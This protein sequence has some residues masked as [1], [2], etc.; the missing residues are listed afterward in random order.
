MEDI[1]G[2]EPELHLVYENGEPRSFEEANEQASWRVAMK[3]EMDT[4]KKNR[5]WEQADLPVGHQAITLKWVFKLKK[6]RQGRSTS[7]RLGS[8]RAGSCS[9]RRS[10]STTPSSVLHGLN[11]CAY[12]LCWKPRRAG[13]SIT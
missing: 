11:L 1:L 5:T 8:W 6:M 9:R 12:S 7:T 3:R 2:V 13:A 10:T 4:M